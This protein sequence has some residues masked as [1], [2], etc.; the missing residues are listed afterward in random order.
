MSISEFFRKLFRRPAPEPE[1][2]SLPEPEPEPK[3]PEERYILCIDGGGMRG[4]IPV[5]YL[6]HLEAKIRKNGG[7]DDIARYFDFI[8]GTST[9]GLITLALTCESSLPHIDY[10]GSMQ[11]DLD[12]L[13]QTYMTMGSEIFQAQT[14]LFG[15]R[16]MVAD[17]YNSNNIQNLCQRWFGVTTMDRAKVPTLIMAYD[18]SEGMPDLIRSYSDEGTYPAWIAARATSAAPTYFSPCEYAG[19]LLVDGGVVANNPATYAYFQAK[20]LY[21]ECEKFHILS[22]STGGTHHT[23]EKEATKGLMNWADQVSPMY[24]TAQKRTTD[25]VLENLHDVEYVRMDEELSAPVKMDE[26]NLA[27]L[28]MMRSEAES[29]ALLYEAELDE[30][31]KRLVE[32]MEYRKDASETG[33]T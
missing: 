22:F 12:N 25:Y 2:Q 33:R 9:G 16:H 32:N 29:N 28:R 31:A 4:I 1:V 26:T 21:P 6:Q 14:S 3:R 15:L 27:V 30:F 10:N 24:S 8:S 17:K 19:K 13:L 11:V 7:T 18:L 20:K 5:V 23:M